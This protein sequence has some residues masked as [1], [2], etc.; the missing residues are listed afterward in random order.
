MTL[1]QILT[2]VMLVSFESATW[3]GFDP[4]LRIRLG[5]YTWTWPRLAP[6]VST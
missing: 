6:D 1:H 5:D 2:N 3:V 4:D